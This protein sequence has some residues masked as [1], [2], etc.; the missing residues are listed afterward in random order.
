MFYRKNMGAMER[1][2]RLVAGGSMLACAFFLLGISP[3]GWLLAGAGVMTAGTGLVGF[4][5]ACAMA[6][7][8][9]VAGPRP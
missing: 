1:V 5:P 6:G 7:R 2:A 8:G 4:C 9:P 3:M